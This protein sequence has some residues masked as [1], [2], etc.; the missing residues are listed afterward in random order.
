[1]KKNSKNETMKSKRETKKVAELE[2]GW[3]R[4]DEREANTLVIG[5]DLGDRTSAYCVRTLGQQIVKEATVATTATA[6]QEA[7]RELSRQRFVIETG[8]HSRW[9]A[10]LLELMGQVAIEA[11]AR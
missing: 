9:V 4:L 5:I 10:Q 7:F 8:R 2:A 11:N 6:M 1:M 3:T